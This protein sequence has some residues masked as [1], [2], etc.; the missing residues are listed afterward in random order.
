M[1][2]L[3]GM[4]QAFGFDFAP[5]N[6][7]RC[8]G[9]LLPISQWTALFSLIGT[10]YGGDGRTTFG[11]PDLRGRTTIGPGRGPGLSN[12][13]WGQ[14]GGAD[15][16]ILV[17]QNLPSHN[18]SVSIPVTTGDAEV[19]TPVNNVF[20]VADEEIYAA[21][22]VAGKSLRAFQT[23]PEGGGQSYDNDM[24]TLTVTMCIAMQGIYPS[25]S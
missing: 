18:H 22:P 21:A 13:V 7:N 6:W 11:L 24:P 25:R 1:E 14:K 10:T 5:R 3:I 16:T 2:P 4:I 12:R 19:D 20:S 9:Q 17:P 23:A 8:E 15:N